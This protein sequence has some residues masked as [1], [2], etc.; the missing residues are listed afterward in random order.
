MGGGENQTSSR[1]A[2]TISWSVTSDPSSFA[3]IVVRPFH[4]LWEVVERPGVQPL[5][6][7]RDT[8]IATARMFLRNRPGIIEVQSRD[9]LVDHRIELRPQPPEAV[10]HFALCPSPC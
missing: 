8:A 5:F 7:S 4:G 6:R 2:D 10:A 9:G 1:E 3:T